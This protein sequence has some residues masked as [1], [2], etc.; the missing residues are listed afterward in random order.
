[1]Q[2]FGV[3]L[4]QLVARVLLQDRDERLGQMPVGKE[5]RASDDVGHLAAH[6]RNV[7][8]RH[9]V[10]VRRVHPQETPLPT[11]T[12]LGVKQFDADVVEIPGPVHGG[13]RVGLGEED[14]LG[15]VDELGRARCQARRVRRG[16]VAQR[17]TQ[18]AQAGARYAAQV[19]AIVLRDQFVI[20]ITKEGEMP[21]DHPGE[22]GL[23]FGDL[24]T[25]HVTGGGLR[26]AYGQRIDGG[27]G[28]RLHGLPV[29][30]R[31]THVAKYTH[32]AVVQSL[33][34]VRFGEPIDL[35]V[36]GRFEAGYAV[37][38]PVR[39]GGCIGHVARKGRRALDTA[40]GRD[41][42]AHACAIALYA[43]DRVEGGMQ[44]QPLP[45]DLHGHGV[46]QERHVV[47]DDF[48]DRVTAVPAVLF[49]ARV[50]D[51]HAR[52]PR[53]EF[54]AQLP[55]RHRR[56]VEVGNAA[57]DHV[58]GVCQT[59]V[60]PQERLEQVGNIGRTFARQGHCIRHVLAD[61]V[62]V[63]GRHEAAPEE[64]LPHATP[65]A[66][67]WQSAC[68]AHG[69]SDA[70]V[71]SA[72]REQ[73]VHSLLAARISD[74]SSSLYDVDA[75]GR[76]TRRDGQQAVHIRVGA[77]AVACIDGVLGKHG[78]AVLGG[79]G[80]E[81]PER[82]LQVVIHRHRTLLA[83]LVFDIGHHCALAVDQIDAFDAVNGGQLG[84]VVL[85]YAGRL[86]HCGCSVG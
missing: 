59:V 35:D 82:L 40:A 18:H 47:V 19:M 51:P 36:D 21:L 8:S 42:H 13:P 72:A 14:G 84:E 7:F 70:A 77:G 16:G 63:L 25:F 4:E 64:G 79:L 83:R 50:V 39:I 1:M 24:G 76:L 44:R 20:T 52:L 9:H 15:C 86:N 62:F 67:G 41:R 32:E 74:A 43:V 58:F 37:G 12:A 38:F 22:E 56:A 46:E 55:V 54:L 53:H 65:R 69:F 81:L 29:F 10:D 48:N 71:C 49:E 2:R 31:G 75:Q 73:V 57:R 23:R 68:A 80:V 45:V 66:H 27:L 5:A 78:Q 11:D 28:G 85:E 33:Q 17:F 61:L 3:H 60:M 34:A 30:H 26:G 6:Q